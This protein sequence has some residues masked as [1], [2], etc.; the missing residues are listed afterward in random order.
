MKK[1]LLIGAALMLLARAAFSQ[2]EIVFDNLANASGTQGEFPGVIRAPIFN[3]DPNN[4][5]A[6]KQGNTAAGLPMGTATYGGAVLAGTGFTATLWALNSANVTGNADA[7]NL[8]LVGTTLM[9]T[10]TTGTS[11]GRVMG[12]AVNPLIPDVRPGTTD[13]GSFQVRV[14]DN[15]G[16]TITTW[17]QVMADNSVARGYSTVFTVPWALTQPG[18]LG[19]PSNLEGLQSFQLFIPVPEPSVIAL[20]VLGAGCLFLLRRRK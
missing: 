13:R 18:A 8:A 7:N 17:S 20:G 3:V 12:S 19:T 5:N 4:R 1:I 15:K 11:A 16:G 6:N 10:S 9:R 2:S 14:W